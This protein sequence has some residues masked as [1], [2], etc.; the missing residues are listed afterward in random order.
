MNVSGI[1]ALRGK[2]EL[3]RQL[4]ALL[5]DAVE[6]FPDADEISFQGLTSAGEPIVAVFENGVG[7]QYIPTE[8]V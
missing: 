5:A 4:D 7:T 2:P 3:R 1:P 8:I 6:T